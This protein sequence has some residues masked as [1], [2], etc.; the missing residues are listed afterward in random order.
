MKLSLFREAAMRHFAKLLFL[1]ALHLFTLSVQAGQVGVNSLHFLTSAKQNRV[2]IDLSAV[3]PHKVALIQQ[4]DRLVIELQNAQLVRKLDQPEGEHPFFT[5]IR[6][7]QKNKNV[8][9]EAKLKRKIDYK[10]FTLNPN[11][12]YGH[13]LIVDFIDKGPLPYSATDREKPQV[14]TV[15]TDLQKKNPAKSPRQT[16]KGSA[17]AKQA[18]ETLSIGRKVKNIVVAIDAGHGGDDPGAHGPG[19]TEEKEVVLAIAK[20]LAGYI[21]AQRGMRAVMVR[22][23]DY[24]VDLRK[25]ME[26]ARAANADLFISVHADAY[27]NPILEALPYLLYQTAAPRAK[28][29]AGS[30]TARMLPTW[31]AG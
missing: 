19:G 31:S 15:Q 6:S 13:R 25:R 24:F 18:K 20:K 16:V 30:L 29:P 10:S 22:K 14:R 27:Q 3:T 2:M 9:I 17:I 11:K 26:I 8:R 1:L 5:G 7:F 4:P 21:N 12:I 28:R 23:G